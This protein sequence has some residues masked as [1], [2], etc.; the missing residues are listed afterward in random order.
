MQAL[1]LSLRQ[2]KDPASPISEMLEHSYQGAR[3][4]RQNHADEPVEPCPRSL[5]VM[6]QGSSSVNEGPLGGFRLNRGESRSVR[7]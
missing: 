4:R 7:G 2:N 6:W 3:I 1:G 5:P